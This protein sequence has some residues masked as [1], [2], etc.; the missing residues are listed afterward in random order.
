MINLEIRSVVAQG[1]GL[2]KGLTT[3]EY[4]GTLQFDGSVSYLN[5]GGVYISVSIC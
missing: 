2:G 1:Q 4:K 5:Y 3:Y